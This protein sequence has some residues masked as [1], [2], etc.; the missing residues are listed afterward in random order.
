M[1]SSSLISAVLVGALLLW[2]IYRRFRRSFGRQILSPARMMF[3]IG[4]LTLFAVLSV[5]RAPGGSWQ[6]IG[7]EALGLA[8]GLALAVW[9]S[10]QTRFE[11]D[12]GRLYY[13]PHTF[14]G[15]V[16]SVL[17]LSRLV[18]RLLY[19]YGATRH[20]GGSAAAPDMSFATAAR[21]PLTMGLFFVLVGY[22]ACF[23]S[24]VLLRSRTERLGIADVAGAPASGGTSKSG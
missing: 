12:Q 10:S 17:F 21:S 8:A 16:V 20:M 9:A 15:V 1:D 5:M 23:Y 24:L 14:S 2:V 22:Y 11:R 18:Y 13:V 6:L 19:V 3:R 4:L 7:A